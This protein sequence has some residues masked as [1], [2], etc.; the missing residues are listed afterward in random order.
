MTSTGNMLIFN[1]PKTLIY[2]KSYAYVFSILLLLILQGCSDVSSIVKKEAVDDVD[3]VWQERQK[4]LY[5]IAAWAIRGRLAVRAEGDAWSASLQW[6]QQKQ[7]YMMRVIAPLGQGTYE[8][9]RGY[10]SVSLLTAEN[11]YY[12]AEDAESLM[13]NNLGW[14]VPVEG[15]KY[16]IRGIP[17]PGNKIENITV[18]EH[19]FMTKLEQSGWEIELSRYTEEGKYYLPGKI[20]MKNSRV[21]ITILA[22]DWIK[23][24]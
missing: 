13:Q 9:K 7:L 11:E 18:D 2:M 8:I 3:L 20:V 15:M 1:A 5:N 6:A 21:K 10:K 12:E 22:K 14:S 4:K 24:I 19:A 16:W 23:I 17:D